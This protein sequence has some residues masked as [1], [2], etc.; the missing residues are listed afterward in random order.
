MKSIKSLGLI[1]AAMAMSGGL[2]GN[3]ERYVEPKET[4]EQRKKR[5]AK[6]E[7]ERN[8]ANGLTEFFYNGNSLW[9]LNQKSADKKAKKKGWI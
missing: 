9:A 3:N 6:A 8:K 2:D 5:A 1:F 7:I 4:E